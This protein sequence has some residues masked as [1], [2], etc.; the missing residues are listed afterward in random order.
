MALPPSNGVL[1]YQRVNNLQSVPISAEG[2]RWNSVEKEEL[3]VDVKEKGGE[4]GKG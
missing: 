1:P 3:N 4:A 2:W